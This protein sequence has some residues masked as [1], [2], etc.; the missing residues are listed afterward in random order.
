MTNIK[1]MNVPT[2]SLPGIYAALMEEIKERR[3]CATKTLSKAHHDVPPYGYLDIEFCYLQVRR[4]CEVLAIAVLIAH[5][6]I[7]SFRSQ[8]MTK[9]WN[10]EALFRQLATLNPTAFPRAMRYTPD[11]ESNVFVGTIANDGVL[12]KDELAKIYHACSD[13]LHTGSLKRLLDHG[14]KRYNVKDVIS[15]LNKIVQL[16]DIHVVVLP[17]GKMMTVEMTGGTDGKAIC[18]MDELELD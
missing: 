3:D 9:E 10:A 7:E 8:K 18:H 12:T 5:N 2:A 15:W 16:L 17:N 1:S 11:E 4:I 14:P 6:E 13:G